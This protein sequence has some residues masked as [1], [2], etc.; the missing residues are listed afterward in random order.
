MHSIVNTPYQETFQPCNFRFKL[1]WVTPNA[2]HTSFDQISNKAQLLA[3]GKTVQAA[4]QQQHQMCN[5]TTACAPLSPQGRRQRKQ[6]DPQS[7]TRQSIGAAAT[8][9]RV[10]WATLCTWGYRMGLFRA[11]KPVPMIMVL[12][13]CSGAVA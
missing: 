8:S 11:D 9:A 7:I 1:C 2:L 6:T 10:P 4:A 5:T 3:D 12:T 13:C